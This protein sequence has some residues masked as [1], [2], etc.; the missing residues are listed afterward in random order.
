MGPKKCKPIEL[1]PWS[2]G[3]ISVCNTYVDATAAAH[4][5]CKGG[6]EGGPV[7]NVAGEADHDGVAGRLAHRGVSITRNWEALLKMTPE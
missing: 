6:A 5:L 2:L 7:R 1:P 4:G 3:K